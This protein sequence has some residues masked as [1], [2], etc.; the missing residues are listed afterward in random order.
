MQWWDM[1]NPL[2][3]AVAGTLLVGWL[4]RRAGHER[5]IWRFAVFLPVIAGAA[6]LTE[7]ILLRAAIAAFPSV[8][9]SA[10]VL[11]DVTK[12]KLLSLMVMVPIAVGLGAV[13]LVGSFRGG[14]RGRVAGVLA[15]ALVITACCESRPMIEGQWIGDLRQ[16]QRSQRMEVSVDSSGMPASVS[17]AGWGLEQAPA[18]AT[19]VGADSLGFTALAGTD[20]AFGARSTADPGAARRGGAPT[21]PLS[22]CGGSTRSPTR[23]GPPS[24]GPTGPARVACWASRP[25]PNSEAVP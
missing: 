8:P 14:Q 21:P 3:V 9:G 15:V 17:I 16:A 23:S 20:T 7:N 24:S 18:S 6:D 12:M 4:I 10:G 22:S 2:L 19:P 11:A 13:A 1:I 25:F 5:R